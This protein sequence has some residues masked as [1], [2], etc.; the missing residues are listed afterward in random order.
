M[1]TLLLIILCFSINNINAQTRKTA[2]F[3]KPTHE[4]LSMKSYDKDPEASGVVLFEKGRHYFAYV[5]D[6]VRLIKEVH[7]KIKVLDA[8]NFNRSEV[9]IPYY[10]GNSLREKVKSI[11]AITHNGQVKVF[12]NENAIYET[13]ETENWSLKRFTFPD[14]QDGSVLEYFYKIQSPYDSFLGDWEFQGDLP[15]LYSE[16]SSEIPGNY[17]YRRSLVGNETLDINE[18]SLKRSCLSLPGISNNAD[19]E[20]TVYA[21][22]DVPAFKE[23]NYMLSKNNYIS[24]IDYELVEFI[25]L[26]GYKKRYTKDWDD[27]DKEFRTDK[28]I[29]RQ[30]KFKSF[31]ADQ[32]PQNILSTTDDLERA[33]KVYSFIQNHFSWN[34]KFHLFTN[35]RVKDAFEKKSGNTSEINLALINALSAANLD[36]KM[37]LIS[38]RTNGLPTELY[39]VISDF[40]YVAAALTINNTDYILDAT[41]KYSPFNIVPFRALNI[42]GRVM[43]FK[44]GSYWKLIEPNKRNV[45]YVSSK[46]EINENG[47]ISGVAKETHSGYMGV[48]KRKTLDENSHSEYLNDKKRGSVDLE[49]SNL[50]IENKDQIGKPLLENYEV[51]LESDVIGDE[52]FFYPFLLRN[53]FSENP[54]KLEKRDYPVD[55]GHPVTNTYLLSL[56]LN[57][58]YTISKL[59]ENKMIKLAGG[60]GECTVL[61]NEANGKLNMRF[62]LKLNQYTYGPEAYKS[63][64]EFFNN[65]INIQTKEAVVLKKL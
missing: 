65:V 63:L 11:K 23:E 19:C 35:V 45:Y 6:K 22:F 33:K 9:F 59:P 52:I 7:R 10:K 29:G 14:V 60:A 38:T 1:R 44:E 32:I 26:R 13:D 3:G 8:Q 64:K 58:L 54:F 15:K 25:D 49:I 47:G 18:V 50:V 31:F 43:D 2:E 28:D 57:D 21:M 12:L 62:S 41:D 37:I 55:F 30:L 61:Y 46:L 34:G 4:E 48:T 42:R 51:S 53:H 36:A 40:N 56:D 16:F 24:K 5:E 17:N 27:V 20:A 39:P